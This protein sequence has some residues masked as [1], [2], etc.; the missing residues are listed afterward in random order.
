MQRALEMV[1]VIG[2]YFLLAVAPSR[3][4]SPPQCAL[5]CATAVLAASGCTAMCVISLSAYEVYRD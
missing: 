3:A 2:V 4:Q 5:Q 1:L